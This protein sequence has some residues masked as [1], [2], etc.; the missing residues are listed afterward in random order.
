[1][2]LNTNTENDNDR[3]CPYD[4]KGCSRFSCKF[5]H[6]NPRGYCRYGK[7]CLQKNICPLRGEGHGENKLTLKSKP[8]HSEMYN[9]ITIDVKET[10]TKERD[11]DY[12]YI[13]RTIK[14]IQSRDI[15]ISLRLDKNAWKS[16][17]TDIIRNGFVLIKAYDKIDMQYAKIKIEK[18]VEE[19]LFYRDKIK[20]FI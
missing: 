9:I 15:Y 7:E 16:D 8:F 1:M 11:N 18:T 13:L 12:F 14:K 6:L 10:G 5:I 2:E 4:Y 19:C 17:E 20:L 3:I